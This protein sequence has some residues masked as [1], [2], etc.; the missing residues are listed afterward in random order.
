MDL[1]ILDLEEFKADVK[2]E[3]ASLSHA[4][5]FY[6]MGQNSIAMQHQYPKSTPLVVMLHGI[7]YE[8]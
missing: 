5:V 6:V 3:T 2:V 4:G 1:S 8:I 7:K